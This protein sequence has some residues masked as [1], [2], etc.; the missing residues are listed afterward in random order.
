MTMLSA[1]EMLAR[2]DER[3]RF[4]LGDCRGVFTQATSQRRK[5]ALLTIHHL[6]Q[7]NIE[8]LKLLL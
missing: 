2:R 7:D 5:C 4:L 3:S 8:L 6:V 1:D